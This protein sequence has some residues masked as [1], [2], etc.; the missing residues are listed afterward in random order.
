MWVQ[1]PVISSIAILENSTGFT[2]VLR[3]AKKKGSASYKIE[4]IGDKK[5]VLMG[6][7]KLRSLVDTTE[8]ENRFVNQ[9]HQRNYDRF[10]KAKLNALFGFKTDTCS[11]HDLRR[12]YARTLC[13][14][15]PNSPQRELIKSNLGHQN[16][17]TGE[18]YENIRII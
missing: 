3:Q 1:P 7:E 10:A 9:K 16:S 18:H 12:I 15:Y 8:L 14:K 17:I 4:T 11:F 5:A 13:H 2:I 6:L